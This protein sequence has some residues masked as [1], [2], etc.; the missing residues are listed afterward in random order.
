MSS[1][2][3]LAKKALAEKVLAAVQEFESVTRHNVLT[4]D[5]PL[6]KAENAPEDAVKTD[7]D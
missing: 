7:E 2:F 4:F 5:I 1:Q 6:L 3:Q